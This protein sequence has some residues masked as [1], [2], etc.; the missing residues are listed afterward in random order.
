MKG[1]NLCHKR[2]RQDLMLNTTGGQIQASLPDG[3]SQ[4]QI[5]VAAV[6]ACMLAQDA[7]S[8]LT[9]AQRHAACC[10]PGVSSPGSASN[11]SWCPAGVGGGAG[12]AV[13]L[14]PGPAVRLVPA[15]QPHS[16]RAAGVR[17]RSAKSVMR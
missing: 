16:G 13:P 1:C 14:P 15:M 8:Q 7:V 5:V 6:H 10:R 11:Q 12:L 4:V 9:W 17:N 3:Q 2:R